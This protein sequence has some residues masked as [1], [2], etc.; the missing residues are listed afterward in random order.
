[1]KKTITSLVYVVGGINVLISFFSLINAVNL[2]G[3]GVSAFTCISLIISI[4]F[5]IVL[6][7]GLVSALNRTEDLEDE[8]NSLRNRNNNSKISDLEYDFK[9]LK[10]AI[11]KNIEDLREKIEQLN[12]TNKK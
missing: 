4:I 8:L 1:M 2:I 11:N 12:T 3:H 6:L 9:D 7:I 10:C 5:N